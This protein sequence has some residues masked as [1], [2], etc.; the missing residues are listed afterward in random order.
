MPNHSKTLSLIIVLTLALALFA[1]T[2][3]AR[4]L[5]TQTPT[6]EPPGV[7]G[8]LD[9]DWK[10]AYHAETGKV[11]FLST[12]SGAAIPQV[13][14][15]APEVPPEAAARLFLESYGELFGLRSQSDELEVKKASSLESNPPESMRR[16][17]VRFQ[18]MYQGI[19]VMGGE[20][21]VG[22]DA[23]NDVL[24]VSGELLPDLAVAP[25]PFISADAARE[26]ALSKVAK[27]Y[28]LDVAG[29]AASLP[30]L[31]IYNPLLLGAPGPR[32][33]SLVWR[34]DVTPVELG[35]IRELV[36]VDAHMGAIV[37]HFNQVDTARNRLTYDANNNT[38]LPG[39][40]VCNESNPSCSGGDTHEEAA[41]E[42]AGR[43]LRFLP[44]RA[45]AG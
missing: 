29:L 9:P 40:L 3:Q 14:A 8:S 10:V 31:W 32:L 7:P 24:S 19:P 21:I 38:F 44:G 37:L 42:Y 28:G 30:E 1:A 16:A 41:H 2:G 4:Q 25:T 17:F 23:R 13:R 15:F 33:D 34:M 18:Q 39:T 43:H 11:R 36:L 12:R 6:A 27:D 20:L 35:P 26:I 22:L 5:E 45:R